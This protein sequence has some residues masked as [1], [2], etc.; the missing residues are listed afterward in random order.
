MTDT[1][2]VNQPQENSP[3]SG[4]RLRARL[5][6]RRR[7]DRGSTL[8]EAAFVMPVFIL[9]IFGIFEFSGAIMTR[10]GENS[11]IKG[12]ARMAV[13]AGNDAMAD[14]Q[15]L[16]RMGKEGS[17][18][19]QDHI[20]Q[21]IIWHVTVNP[22]TGKFTNP[23]PPASCPKG[24]GCNLYANPQ[25]PATGAFARAALPMS[26]SPS[27]ATSDNADYYFGCDTST[28]QG[29]IDSAS[30]LD[31]G[32]EPPKRRIAER[33]PSYTCTSNSDAKCAATDLVGISITVTHQYYTGFF[34]KQ[35]TLTMQ[36]IAAIEP[37]GYDK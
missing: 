4:G 34:G 25:T 26:V 22:A 17:G 18:I 13:V 3:V 20:D 31:C 5:R 29:I 7:D 35:V 19:S 6:H 23:T 1:P 9:M 24:S 8:V 10:T 16:L 30:K 11:A 33:S 14:R 28:P 15:I 12:G 21:V 2:K 27:L 37:Q 32:W 36:T